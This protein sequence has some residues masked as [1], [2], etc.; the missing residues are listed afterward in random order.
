MNSYWMKTIVGEEEK[1]Q[2]GMKSRAEQSRRKQD[3]RTSKRRRRRRRCT[4]I[5]TEYED[6]S[7]N[8]E[9]WSQKNVR[10]ASRV[11]LSAADQRSAGQMIGGAA[12]RFFTSATRSRCQRS[13]SQIEQLGCNRHGLAHSLQDPLETTGWPL[14]LDA[15]PA[16]RTNT[17]R[18]PN[19]NIK[20][21]K[22]Q[23][24][25]T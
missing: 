16:E 22:H 21:S 5:R 10:D 8:D 6:A 12:A 19:K 15:Q 7:L 9:V 3:N 17:K 25:K 11:R 4:S 24:M 20:T 23:N 2:D 13:K 14:L 1:T 18:K